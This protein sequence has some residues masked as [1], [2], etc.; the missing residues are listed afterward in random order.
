[1][2]IAA[3][4][5]QSDYYSFGLEVRYAFE[6]ENPPEKKTSKGKQERKLKVWLLEDCLTAK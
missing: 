6:R 2:V 4:G 5:S 1:M 3:E